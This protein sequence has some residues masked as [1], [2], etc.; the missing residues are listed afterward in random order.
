VTLQKTNAGEYEMSPQ[1]ALL[2]G[3]YA[4]VLRPISKNEKVSGGDVARGQGP[5]LMFDTLWSFRVS[6]DAQ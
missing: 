6:D 2:P 3:E 5:G 4:V 1:S